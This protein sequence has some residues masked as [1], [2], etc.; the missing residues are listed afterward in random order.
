MRRSVSWS[1]AQATVT[2][3][4][5]TALAFLIAEVFQPRWAGYGVFFAA[6][7]SEGTNF[8]FSLVAPLT[9]TLLHAGLTHLLVNLV[10]LLFCGRAVEGTLGPVNLAILYIA[11]AYAA[12]IAHFALGPDLPYPMLGAGGAVAAVI[13]AYANFFGRDHVPAA[14]ARASVGLSFLAVLAGWLVLQVALIIIVSGGASG[15]LILLT[16]G[17]QAAGFLAGILL[18]RPLLLWRYRKA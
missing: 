17:A 1:N 13:G 14:N 10:V 7:W 9:T 5:A 3:V 8:P 16:V 12:A 6:G 2:I 18:A 15:A 11:G 4:L